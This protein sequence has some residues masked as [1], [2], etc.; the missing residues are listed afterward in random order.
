VTVL[1]GSI[2]ERPDTNA[3]PED[4]IPVFQA[5]EEHET[6]THKYPIDPL[7]E[8]LANDD[9][10]LDRKPQPD[11]YSYGEEFYE[12]EGTDAIIRV[13]WSEYQ[14]KDGRMIEAELAFI[15]EFTGPK[16]REVEDNIVTQHSA[17]YFEPKVE[18]TAGVADM[19]LPEDYD[20]G[21]WEQSVESAIT[22]ARELQDY[23]DTL[24]D[25]TKTYLE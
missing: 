16:V 22:A 3:E 5:F 14:R 1:G 10:S 21:G 12:I 23:H 19:D 11:E 17:P 6:V 15:D 9:F 24:H 25:A 7:T 13:W 18:D 20:Q 8:T 2:I 4:W